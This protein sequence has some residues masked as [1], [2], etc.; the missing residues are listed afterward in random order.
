VN[1]VE[2]SRTGGGS[3]MESAVVHGPSTVR[4]STTRPT[5][6]CRPDR[7]QCGDV[8]RE[9]SQAPEFIRCVV[10]SFVTGLA[11]E[12]TVGDLVIATGA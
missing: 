9:N 2:H 12:L 10:R 8:T 6:L 1:A 4:D 11:Q 7:P 3:N 5:N